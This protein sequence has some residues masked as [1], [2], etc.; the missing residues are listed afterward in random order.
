MLP[1][2]LSRWSARPPASRRPRRFA[3][4]LDSLEGRRLLSAPRTVV[5]VLTEA[6]A[7]TVLWPPNGRIV[8]VHVTGTVTRELDGRF[9]QLIYVVNDEYGQFNS[10]GP[11]SV[12]RNGVYSFHVGLQSSRLGQDQDGRQYVIAVAAIDT[13]DHTV[14]VDTAVVTVPHD[15]GHGN[16]GNGSVGGGSGNG[17]GNDQG[18]GH[19]NGQGNDHGNGQ[20]HGNSHGNGHGN[21]HGNSHGKKGG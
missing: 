18:N 8:P 3:P 13:F 15:M 4:D 21:G 12:N 7:P 10:S 9:P 20:G 2:L 19:G 11:V 6:V 5:P 17:Q 1:R 16:S 14:S